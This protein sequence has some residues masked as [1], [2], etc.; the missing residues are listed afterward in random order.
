MS[1]I[2]DFSDSELWIIKSTLAERYGTAP[3]INLAETE[4]RLNRRL[5]LRGRQDR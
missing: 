2:P 3:E 4:M 1:V 5:S